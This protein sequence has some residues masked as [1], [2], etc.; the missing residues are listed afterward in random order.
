M[1]F[2]VEGHLAGGTI[3][4]PR[5]RLPLRFACA[6]GL[7]GQLEHNIGPGTRLAIGGLE[8]RR[9]GRPGGVVRRR[10]LMR[11]DGPPWWRTDPP[12]RQQ[13]EGQGSG[14]ASDGRRLGARTAMWVCVASSSSSARGRRSG[15]W[16]CHGERDDSLPVSQ[17]R[18]GDRARGGG[19]TVARLPP[20]SAARPLGLQV[21]EWCA[22]SEKSG[23]GERATAGWDYGA[24]LSEGDLVGRKDRLLLQRSDPSL[25]TAARD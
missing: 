10:Q 7:R 6:R 8:E 14:H 4:R 2:W 9:R 20:G 12:L 17:R 21:C 15:S 11:G 18:T 24:R 1:S 16:S 23:H 25:R 5:L 22:G 19:A 3:A 13:G